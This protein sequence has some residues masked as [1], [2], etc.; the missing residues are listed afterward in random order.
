MQNSPNT[1]I[2][3]EFPTFKF[4]AVC[5]GGKLVFS[6][7]ST[8]TE[9]T[10]IFKTLFLAIVLKAIHQFE[11]WWH[12]CFRYHFPNNLKPS[13]HLCVPAQQFKDRERSLWFNH[14]IPIINCT[15]CHIFK[16]F[17]LMVESHWVKPAPP[18][19]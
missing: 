19:P 16:E 18:F 5:K 6:E 8:L 17:N 1:H 15:S 7:Q 11:C 9:H 13:P 4:S 10:V 3:N 14:W 12:F 2:F